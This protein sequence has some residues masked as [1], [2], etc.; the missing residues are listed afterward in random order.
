M[1]MTTHKIATVF[2]AVFLFISCSNKKHHS[3]CV[4]YKV[5]AYSSRPYNILIVYK[6]S[7]GNVALYIKDKSWSKDVCLPEG[8][9]ASLAVEIRRDMGIHV[10]DTGYWYEDF[11]PSVSAQIIHEKKMVRDSGS[12]LLL[13]SLFP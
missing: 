6:D 10:L 13:L 11:E 9:S 5:E 2:L 3:T 4:I 1:T 7:T 8:Q 12:G